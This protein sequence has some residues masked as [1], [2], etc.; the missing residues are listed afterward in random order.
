[1]WTGSS[2]KSQID[3]FD[4]CAALASARLQ[5]FAKE[6]LL[7]TPDVDAIFGLEEFMVLAR[8]SVSEEGLIG[9]LERLD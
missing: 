4:G 6:G 8:I 7:V 1:V 2:W 9:L 3:I 5:I